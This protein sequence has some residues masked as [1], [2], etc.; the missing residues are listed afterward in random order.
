MEAHADSAGTP[1][2]AR[3]R[4]DRATLACRPSWRQHPE[5]STS[6]ATTAAAPLMLGVAAV[7]VVLVC[8]LTTALAVV[9]TAVLAVRSLL[10]RLPGPGKDCKQS[11][12]QRRPSAEG[13]LEGSAA[14]P[15]VLRG[16]DG[17]C[18]EV[19]PPHWGITLAQCREFFAECR[20]DPRWRSTNSVYTLVEEYIKPR[21]AGSG[22][23]LALMCNQA[24]PLEV[25][26]MVSHA[27]SENAEEFIK[28][29][30]L[31][32]SKNDVLFIC[33][34]SLYQCQDHVG[35]TIAEQLGAGAADSPFR[36]VLEHVGAAGAR[37]AALWR[38]GAYVRIIPGASALIALTLLFFPVITAGCVP[39]FATLQEMICCGSTKLSASHDLNWGAFRGKWHTV[40][41]DALHPTRELAAF[42]FFGSLA[43]AAGAL[44]AQGLLWAVRPYRGRMLVVPNRQC[45][46]YT[47]L[48]CVYEIFVAKSLAVPVVLAH[49]LARAGACSSRDAIC[50]SYEDTERIRGEI[51]AYYGVELSG[52]AGRG[53]SFVDDAIT[54]TTRSSRRTLLLPMI[55]Q[56]W[57][58]MLCTLGVSRIC[59][60]V[61]PDRELQ[62]V[63][64]ALIGFVLGDGCVF[65]ALY[66][67]AR[68][69]EGRPTR[70]DMASL[71]VVFGFTGFAILLVDLVC[72][73]SQQ[74]FTVMYEMPLLMLVWVYTA[75]SASIALFL[76]IHGLA[77]SQF[78]S[79]QWWAY[80][81]TKA[82][83]VLHFVV[84]PLAAFG[85]ISLEGASTLTFY[86]IG[87]MAFLGFPATIAGAALAWNVRFHNPEKAVAETHQVSEE[88]L[89]DEDDAL[90]PRAG[91]LQN[92]FSTTA[93]LQLRLQPRD[94]LASCA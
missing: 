50:G 4:D 19:W 27:W 28:A 80:A 53:Y 65:S 63:C 34:F 6:A 43:C 58:M 31:S 47:R 54:R 73:S 48:W 75:S 88:G 52:Q 57:P 11:P 82:Q 87:T 26:L 92:L 71:A 16:E 60:T 22:M 17:Q 25:N 76:L 30:E 21:T 93:G 77:R 8:P 2:Y 37:D 67:V 61:P 5:I 70:C 49:T 94:P 79:A 10:C 56:H 32:V 33:A 46:I 35:P 45:D 62:W 86:A 23:G 74:S 41:P 9:A 14:R 69:K 90:L 55:L 91:F 84:F 20:A 44:I 40:R 89:E 38:W 13:D 7:G 59:A 64:E 29:L 42:S 36:R 66:F 15:Q 78:S 72:K 85:L 24:S 12:P 83:P 18:Q 3:I 39:N 81:F 1:V 68:R 51:E